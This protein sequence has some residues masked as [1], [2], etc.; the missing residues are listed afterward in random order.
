MVTLTRIRTQISVSG[1]PQAECCDGIPCLV[2][3]FAQRPWLLVAEARWDDQR[4]CLVVR[5]EREGSSLEVEG[6]ATGATLDEVC[7]CV[8]ACFR[9]ESGDVRFDVDSSV[10]V[11]PEP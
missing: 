11:D 5:I 4:N 6:G 8:F 3:E 9:M 1:I 10:L 2:A 7:D